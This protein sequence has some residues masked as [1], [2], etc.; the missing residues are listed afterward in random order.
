MPR[1]KYGKHI[2]TWHMSRETDQQRLSNISCMYCFDTD[3]KTHRY[4]II[5]KWTY[6]HQIMKDF[7]MFPACIV[8]IQISKHINIYI[9]IIINIWTYEHQIM[10]FNVSC[11]L[12]L[13]QVISI[14][15]KV[16]M[17]V[18]GRDKFLLAS[19]HTLAEKFPVLQN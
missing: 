17:C 18:L 3:F 10:N 5:N 11:C 2:Q 14:D 16:N 7:Q 4:T 19:Y 13:I 9:Y 8:L 1:V 6:E 12:S 15:I